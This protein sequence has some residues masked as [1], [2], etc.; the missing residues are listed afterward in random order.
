MMHPIQCTLRLMGPRDPGYTMGPRPWAQTGFPIFKR[1]KMMWCDVSFPYFQRGRCEMWYDVS[2][3][4]FM[5]KRMWCDVSPRSGDSGSGWA[6]EYHQ[7]QKSKGEEVGSSKCRLDIF[8]FWIGWVELFLG[9]W[10]DCTKG[11][12]C[13]VTRKCIALLPRQ[14]I[15][16]IFNA[17]L[18]WMIYNF[19]ALFASQ[20]PPIFA[21]NGY[22]LFWPNGHCRFNQ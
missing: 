2:F 13:L 15:V 21:T 14:L 1:N 5:Q 16:M 18:I 4:M 6:A 8:D 12:S 22:F 10:V 9:G 17:P 11:D 3:P 7:M 19:N 20:P